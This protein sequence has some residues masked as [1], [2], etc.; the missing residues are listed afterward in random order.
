[1]ATRT[2]AVF[3]GGKELERALLEL[4]T[5]SAQKVGRAALRKAARPIANK[6]KAV[7]RKKSGA[8]AKA[9]TLR[10]DRMRGNQSLFSA[11]VYVSGKKGD[12]R[13]RRSNR[14]SRIKGKLVE[15]R[16]AYQ[17]GTRPD[18]YARFLE[19]GRHKQGVRAFPFMRPAWDSE[20]G[21]VAQGRL[22]DALWEGI[23]KEA[24]RVAP[25]LKVN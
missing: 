2:Q 1:M 6:A 20:G 18:V 17:I 15:A 21:R 23:S 22:G 9:I 7:V 25:G 13:P 14:R 24:K 8:V 10:V 5:K 4:S 12:Y 11:L 16:Y 19:Y 3:S